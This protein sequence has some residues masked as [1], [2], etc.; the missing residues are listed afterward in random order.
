[1]IG[2]NRD[3]KPSEANTVYLVGSDRISSELHEISRAA[4]RR[5][6]DAADA[7]LR[8][9]RSGRSRAA[10]LPQRS[11]QLRGEGHPGHLLHDRACIPTTTPTPT[12][13]S[14]I[15][16]DKLTRVDAARLRDRV[17]GSPISITRPAR[18]NRGPRAGKGD[19]RYG[20]AP[21]LDHLS[22]RSSSTSSASASSFRCCRSTR[23]RSAR[24]RSPSACCSRCSRS[25][26]LIAAPMLGEL[27]DRYGR[28]PV[29]IFSLAGTVVSFVMLAI[30]QQ[31]CDAVRWRASS[32]GCR[33]ATSRRRAPTSPTSPSRRIARAPT[34]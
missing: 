22:S 4:N 13:S 1:M 26:Q 6:A 3:D 20:D 7:Q 24:R 10:L 33:A 31:L 32:T 23:R 34:G 15:E 16:F 30:A 17:R 9:E 21:L 25:C 19:V 8:D 12:R 18:D 14:K 11:L 2:R 27:S 28:R 29:L 5:A